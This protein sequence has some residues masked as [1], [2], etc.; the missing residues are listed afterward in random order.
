MVNSLKEDAEELAKILRSK[1]LDNTKNV[2]KRIQK[3]YQLINGD[4]KVIDVN[5]NFS[6]H[7]ANLVELEKNEFNIIIKELEK[8]WLKEYSSQEIKLEQIQNIVLKIK[9]LDKEKYD[10]LELFYE[11]NELTSEI[12]NH[13]SYSNKQS[14]KSRAGS[15]FEHH[16]SFLFDILD[17]K[18]E[19]QV[20]LG[21]SSETFDFIFPNKELIKIAPASCMLVEAQTTINDRFRLTTGKGDAVKGA[22]RFL[23]TLS[24]LGIISARDVNFLTDSKLD[25]MRD[26]RVSL[27]VHH[28][29]KQKLQRPDVHSFEDFCNIIYAGKKDLW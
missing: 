10:N 23:M 3:K 6:N 26:K 12:M 1:H 8:N 2:A 20:A 22:Q 13:I 19:D 24:G 17:M 18:Y 25:E 27:V 5:T 28:D 4:L 7:I 29:V 16:L 21:T 9:K 14:S 15:C 11:F